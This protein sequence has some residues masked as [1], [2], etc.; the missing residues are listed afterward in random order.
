MSKP[1]KENDELNL[2]I[3][4][5]NKRFNTVTDFIRY[6]AFAGPCTEKHPSIEKLSRKS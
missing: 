1:K 3:Y 5:L 2:A 6:W 4:L